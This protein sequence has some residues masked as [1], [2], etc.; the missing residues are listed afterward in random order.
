MMATGE[1][2]SLEDQIDRWRNY[3]G[4]RQAIH[5]VDVAELEDHLR[6][7][8]AVLGKGGL[9]ADEAFLVAVKRLGEIDALS[10]EFAREHSDRL[11]KQLVV[12]PSDTEEPQVGLQKDAIVAFSL[13]VAAAVLVKAPAL[14]G[15]QLDADAGFYARNLSL[16][17]LPPLTGYFAWKRRLDLRAIGWLAAMF[18]AAAVVANVYPFAPGGST[19]GL[20][21]LHLPISLWLLVGIAYA[22]QRWNEIGGRM[23][24][25]RFS[26]ELF[27]YYVLIALGG[28]VLTAFMAMMF[29]AVGIDIEPLFESWLLPC[30][31]AG[32]AVIGSWLVEAKQSVIENMA[33]V[34]ARLFTPL[35]AAVLIAFLGTLLWTGRGV[36]IERNLLIGFDLLL[37]LVLGLL[38]YSLSARD[39]RLP[40]GAFDAVQVVLVISA[41]LADAVA[42]WAIAARITEFGFSP[43]R[44]AALGLNIILLVNLAWSAVLYI[45]FLK[46]EASFTR[47]ERWQTDYL[48]VYPVWAAIVVV[49][50]PPI[51]GFI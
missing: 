37:V 34:L 24:F 39:P 6:E 13:A 28:G 3:L 47:L 16:F 35:F 27:I 15:M 44:V 14:F 2:V 40:P 36:D 46:G 18:G 42:L 5:S 29:Q 20:S 48:P 30:G 22:G 1:A 8:I 32:A 38:L 19:E 9:A 51:F 45:R 31:A 17:V 23:D 21:A 4:R 43:N 7:Q 50:F 25:I 49:A 12:S 11:W 33:P 41:L 26:G 10:R